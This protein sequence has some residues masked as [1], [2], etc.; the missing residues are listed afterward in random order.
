[1]KSSKLTNLLFALFL[2]VPAFIFSQ[3]PKPQ[4]PKKYLDV[5][6][7]FQKANNYNDAIDNYTK[8]LDIDPKLEKA[9]VERAL[10]YEKV[11]K[12]EEAIEDYKKA[13]AFMPKEKELYYQAGRLM[14]EINL[15]TDADLMLRKA[16][17]RD[18]GYTEA[19]AAEVKVLFKLRDYNYGLVVTQMGLDDKKTAINYYNHAVMYDSLKNY[20]EAEKFYKSAKTEDPKF[21][22][23]Y[24][25]LALVEVKLNKNEDAMKVCM[26][27]LAKEPDNIDVYYAR[28]VVNA[29]KK[30]FT[31]AINDITKVILT[32]PGADVYKLR[33]SFY[34]TL[35]QHQ[36]AVGDYTQVIKMD[37]RNVGAYLSRAK[38]NEQ[39]QN[40]KSALADYNKVALLA[41]GNASID[42]AIK[43]A[44]Q[45]IFELN[46]E[47]VKP[48]IEL[49][50]LKTDKNVIK[51]SADKN[52]LV[53]KGVVKD[54]SPIKSMNVNSGT[55][56][57]AVD[58]V[59]PEFTLKITDLIK[60]NEI[61]VSAT[62]VYNNT[63][64]SQYKIEKTESDKPI[65][66]IETPVASFENE[67]F[68]DNTNAEVYMQGKIKDASL[69]ESITID[70]VIASFNPTMLN[71]DF[72]TQVKIA[73]KNK[74]TIAVKDIYGNENVQIYA[75]NRSGATAGVDN[76][77]GNTWVVFIENSKY[78]SFPS[79]EGPAKDVTAMKSALANYKITKTLHKKD[80]TKSEME[81]FFSIELRDYVKNNNVNSLLIWYAGHGK[82]VSPTG[83]W[84][85]SDG[86]TD[87]EFSYFGINNLKAAMQ[88][89]AGK[90]VH[91]LVITDACESGATFLMAMRGGDDEKKCD[92]W[93]LTKAKS[94]QV[95]TS[96]GYEL[97]SDNSQFTKTFVSCLNN[98]VDPCIPIEKIVKK[99][100]VSVSQAGNQAPKF[101]KIK[102][103]E[104]E[105]GTY[106]FIK[107]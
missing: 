42:G 14:I 39:I 63:Q 12:K 70:G 81:K 90:L 22:A 54:A 67:L 59:N 10:C 87:D 52:E 51:V 23:A 91:T 85:P 80:M 50:S 49:T 29:A 18:K 62:D 16:L 21:I 78:L 57:F 94:A 95:F 8:A 48:E 71:P 20:T 19:I 106:F 97:A 82:Y 89:Y 5:A 79:L 76:P 77:M 13:Q 56:T 46:K 99:V 7:K 73:D 26:E 37:D 32:S 66:A 65:I 60:L 43:Q 103:L 75:L 3:T 25:A 34:E 83:Y 38:A 102:D 41:A 40:F 1:M 68:I 9:Y 30:E 107:K 69:I 2:I 27:A 4:S 104:D 44:R 101:G 58:S 72:S 93:E 17:E 86:K 15:Y 88:S 24:V 28:S 11:N 92:N 96:A 105:G 31:A 47:S 45:K 64:I 6:E 100:S 36:N 61:T 35:G 33:A 74:I 84:V 53:I 55:A 98:N